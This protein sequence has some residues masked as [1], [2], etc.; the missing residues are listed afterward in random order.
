MSEVR[1]PICKKFKTV[2]PS[3][4]TSCFLA[5][6]IGCAEG[7][8]RAHAAGKSMLEM[9]RLKYEPEV[10]EAT[11]KVA[12][13]NRVIAVLVPVSVLC[14]LAAIAGWVR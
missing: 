14:A 2:G 7:L 5:Y 9:Y 12:Q 6:T 13:L 8:N 11:S 4:C 3:Y 1:C 10:A